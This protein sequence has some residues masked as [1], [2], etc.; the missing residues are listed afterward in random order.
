[1]GRAQALGFPQNGGH[2]VVARH[3]VSHKFDVCFLL[4]GRGAEQLESRILQ[5]FAV[6]E[7]LDLA[8]NHFQA[9]GECVSVRA[10]RERARQQLRRQNPQ[11]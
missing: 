1:M 5:P 10:C 3:F 9:N 11:P 2:G 4:A 7:E 8:V 6:V